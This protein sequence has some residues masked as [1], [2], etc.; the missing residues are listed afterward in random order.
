M[1]ARVDRKSSPMNPD[2]EKSIR[3]YMRS[4]IN[5]DG[6]T[7]E[8][9]SR[10]KRSHRKRGSKKSKVNQ[11]S[12]DLLPISEMYSEKAVVVAD[13]EKKAKR[14]DKLADK[15][16]SR[17]KAE[18]ARESSKPRKRKRDLKEEKTQAEEERLLRLLLK[19]FSQETVKDEEGVSDEEPAEPLEEKITKPDEL[20]DEE[21]DEEV[22]KSTKS[23]KSKREKEGKKE[24]LPEE[25]NRQLSEDEE[26]SVSRDSKQ[27]ET[28]TDKH[29]DAVEEKK[30]E[31]PEATEPRHPGPST[32]D[33]STI[34]TILDA[35]AKAIRS[36]SAPTLPMLDQLSEDTASAKGMILAFNIPLG[37]SKG[38]SKLQKPKSEKAYH[39]RLL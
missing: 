1:T 10:V 39:R 6:E 13:K 24:V 3:E 26:N 35:I 11:K 37:L 34:M 31:D 25:T 21:D 20:S 38:L 14:N 36:D 2:L 33:W 27:E 29:K 28:T 7:S 22:T 5:E 16:S 4:L 12:T 32:K 8:S 30:E 17:N 19:T 23:R 18:R 9:L 15:H